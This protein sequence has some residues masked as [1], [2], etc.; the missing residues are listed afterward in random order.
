MITMGAVVKYGPS[1]NEP[2]TSSVLVDDV[3]FIYLEPVIEPVSS[4][5]TA[6]K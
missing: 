4:L 1:L 6:L 5:E 3:S 2:M